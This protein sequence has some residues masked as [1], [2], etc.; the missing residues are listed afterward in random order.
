MKWNV[1]SLAKSLAQVLVPTKCTADH[2]DLTTGL[3]HIPGGGVEKKGVLR[4]IVTSFACGARPQV[5][6]T[7]PG[8]GVLRDRKQGHGEIRSCAPTSV[9]PPTP[10]LSYGPLALPQNPNPSYHPSLCSTH[11]RQSWLVL[12]QGL[13]SPK[14]ST[15]TLLTPKGLLRQV[16]HMSRRQTRWGL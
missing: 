16:S 15:T 9:P 2:C 3:S 13:Q 7:A 14:V 1:K 11:P 6:D 4:K 5:A 12:P 10:H 8:E